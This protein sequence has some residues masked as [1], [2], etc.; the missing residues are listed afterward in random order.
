[1]D[2]HVTRYSV[3]PIPATEANTTFFSAGAIRLGVEFREL[4][5]AVAAA[6]VLES[7]SGDERGQTTELDDR[8]VSIHVFGH[9]DGEERE[10]L[11]FD[12]FLEDPHYHYISWR[13]RRNEMLHMDPIMSGD[14]VEFALECIGRRLPSLLARA[15][16][17][18]VASAV[19]L[20]QVEQALPAVRAAAMR[21]RDV[22]AAKEATR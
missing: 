21:L 18:D 8:G 3:M 20:A 11:R 13:E 5:D 14:P 19:D 2:S 12:C 15:G 16:A 9:Q 1:M 4:T 10:F 6:A 17:P 7:A 22:G